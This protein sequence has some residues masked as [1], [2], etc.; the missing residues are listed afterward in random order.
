MHRTFN[1]GTGF[2]AAV[3]RERADDVVG[4][5]ED[6]RIIGRVEEDEEGDGVVEIRGLALS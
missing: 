6:G 2:V 1:V 5:T 4:A 3:S